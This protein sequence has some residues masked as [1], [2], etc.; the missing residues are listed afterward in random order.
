MAVVV[1]DELRNRI[2]TLYKAGF[3]YRDIARVLR[4]E[5]WIPPADVR[6]DIRN[7][8]NLVKSFNLP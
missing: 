5:G 2:V 7:I 1:P 8:A 3:G 6:F 4:S